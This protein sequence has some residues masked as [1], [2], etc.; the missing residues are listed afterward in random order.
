MQNDTFWVFSHREA[1]Q[2]N[3]A[4]VSGHWEAV[5]INFAW[6]PSRRDEMQNDFK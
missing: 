5:H 3:F 4:S 2:N 6:I 1:V